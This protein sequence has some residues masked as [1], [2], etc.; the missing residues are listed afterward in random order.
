MSGPFST[1]A[2]QQAFDEAE[3]GLRLQRVQIGLILGVLMM[4]AGIA[5]DWTFYPTKLLPL[6]AIRAA[7]TIFMAVCL[8]LAWKVPLKNWLRPLSLAI[9]LAPAWGIALMV[10]L[11]D[12]EQST[13]FVGLILLMIV[14]QLLGYSVYEATLF[15]GL[16]I[17]AYLLAIVANRPLADMDV[18]KLTLGTFFLLTT[19][20][21]SI[22]VCHLNL[23]NRRTDFALRRTLD[24]KNHQLEELDRLRAGFL[25]NVSHEL[26][27]PLSLIIAPL[28]DILSQRTT[29][30]PEMGQTLSLVRKNADRLRSLVDDLLDVVR[31][32][33]GVMRLDV[34]EVDAREFLQHIVRTLVPMA[35]DK[36]I[37]LVS[38]LQTAPLDLRI[39]FGRIERVLMNLISNSIKF[40]PEKTTVRV[41][42]TSRERKAIISVIDEGPGIPEADRVQIFDRFFQASNNRAR[43]SQ[44]LGL[45]LAIARE[46]VRAHGGEI[47]VT[48]NIG[49]GCQFLVTLPLEWHP[50]EHHADVPAPAVR[51]F[52]AIPSL[53]E[54]TAAANAAAA[55]RAAKEGPVE[56]V[57][58]DDEPDLRNYLQSSLQSE[59]VTQSAATV[60][61]GI[62]LIRELSPAC[63]LLDLMLPDGSGL[64]VLQ[65][66]R[67]DAQLRDTKVIMLTA[68]L[69]E[70]VKID[71]L[72]LG[73]D[74]FLSKPFGITEVRT[75]VAGMVRSSQLQRQLR[76]E[77][78]E[79]QAS[80]VRLRETEVKLFQSEKMRG[81]GSLAA[82]LLH[83]INN[84]VHYTTLAIKT[85]KKDLQVGRDP[86]EVI[87]DIESGVGRIGQIIA[88]LRAFAY[89][90]QAQV[91]RDIS[92]RDAVRT[93]LRFTAHVTREIAVHNLTDADNSSFVRGSEIQIG[94]VLVNLISNAAA[95]IHARGENSVGQNFS[96][97]LTI[98]AHRRGD[99]LVVTISDN[100]CGIPAANLSRVCEP[101]YTSS[102]PGGG[103]GLGLSICDT[104]IRNH[105]GSL[106][107]RSTEQVG[108]DVSFDLPLV[109][110]EGSMH[111][112][113]TLAE[114]NTLRR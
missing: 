64:D 9:V 51:S 24:D 53:A 102:G 41:Q 114:T 45:G 18:S 17:G 40:S 39:D 22:V 29:V 96:G 6:V 21:V 38:D 77:R 36:H 48:N 28:E 12:A 60:A 63:V 79:L 93:A 92:L 85:L 89:P 30:A 49:A 8:V 78:E 107:F 100:G 52:Q 70:T 84:P 42:L 37:K 95:A 103:L 33:H 27:T 109:P 112:D 44:G 105:G 81:L 35:E 14:I 86:A 72:R 20:A 82:G 23:R 110:S 13:Y 83:E 67:D 74:D 43:A 98:K 80:L 19:S 11:T 47:E 106:V 71:A 88:D 66:I 25:A 99:R 54:V 2:D 46:I 69:D 55:A 87:D 61:Q 58:V 62:A 1:T 76:R 113:S 73:A 4:P 68:N 94:Q 65:A 7:V 31:I 59:F 16:V 97:E 101:F 50:P 111:D 15:C 91:E 75:R 90:E 32:D 56:L 10:Y 34:E 104:I 5:L 108:T 57:I 3:A 26:R